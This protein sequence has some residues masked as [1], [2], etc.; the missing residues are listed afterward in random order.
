MS[1]YSSLAEFKERAGYEIDGV[2]YPRVTSILAIKAKP[3][4][5]R[6]YASMPSFRAADEAKDR[7][8][9]EGTLVHSMVEA[10]LRDEHPTID[11]TIRPSVDAF[12]EFR[13]NND[14]VPLKI[15]ERIIS[16]SHHYAGTIDV[17]ARVNG[18]VGVLDIK[19]SKAIYRDYGMQTAAYIAAL[20]EDP[21]PHPQTSWILRLDQC[22]TCQLCGATMRN[23]GGNT[24]VSGG[25]YRCGHQWGHMEG[26][27][28]FQEVPHYEHNLAAFWPPSSSGNGNTIPIWRSFVND[29]WPPG[30]TLLPGQWTGNPSRFC[31]YL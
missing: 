8:A 24:K 27:F 12:L 28:D 7:S 15:E 25:M 11:E 30:Y 23:K 18:V 20:R 2:W 22:Q 6:Y 3:A 17:M 9:V 21:V 16:R 1:E 5:Y 31:W 4:L 29:S 13:R 19:T 14:V 10:L 26:I